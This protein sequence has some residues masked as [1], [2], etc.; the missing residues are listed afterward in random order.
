MTVT[1]K[2]DAASRLA[3]LDLA[4]VDPADIDRLARR[5]AVPDERVRDGARAIL[6]DVASRGAAAVREAAARFGGGSADGRLLIDADELAAAAGRLT[7]AVRRALDEAIENVR[8][9]AASQLPGTTR[10]T[11]RDG[12]DI[13]RRWLPLRRVG[14]YVPG[15]SAPYPSSLVMTVVPARVAGVREIV[16]ASPAD[17][18]GA[19]DPVLLGAAGLL[20]V[21]ALLVAG[22]AQAIGA[23][24]HGLPDAGF[25]PVDRIVGPGNAW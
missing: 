22:G 9:F 10:T 3:R 20:G 23:L 16:V 4:T 19:I 8:R 5:G 1:T 7:P 2:A 25:R 18:D 11:I 13:E 6:A 21:D 24:A 12:V 15:G 14:C 17:G